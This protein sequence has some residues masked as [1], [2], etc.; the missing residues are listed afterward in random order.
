VQAKAFVGRNILAGPQLLFS[1][2]P[3]ATKPVSFIMQ[4][5]LKDFYAVGD[6]LPGN[7]L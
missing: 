2:Q 6:I 4:Y 1:V 5:V 3:D 7:L